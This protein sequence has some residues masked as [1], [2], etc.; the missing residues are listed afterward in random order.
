MPS[1]SDSLRLGLLGFP[2]AWCATAA[3]FAA[4]DIPVAT[5]AGFT[6][7]IRDAGPGDVLLGMRGDR[8]ATRRPADCVIAR[9]RIDT[10]RG[11]AFDTRCATDGIRFAD[12]TT[13]PAAAAGPAAT[14]TDGHVGPAWRR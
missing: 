10:R 4:A 2:P 12:N 7:A 9:N 11:P 13:A 8:K 1:L 14:G 3:P 6:T 5:P